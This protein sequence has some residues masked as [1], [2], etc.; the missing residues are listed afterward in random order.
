MISRYCHLENYWKIDGKPVICIW[1]ARR[2]ESK[3]GIEGVR[4]LF[5]DLTEYAKSLDIKGYIFMQRALV[6]TI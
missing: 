4:Q 5:A 2:L 3:L 6:V 1:D